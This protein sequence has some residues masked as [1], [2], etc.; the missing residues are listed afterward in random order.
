[1][2]NIN[3]FDTTLD[4]DILNYLYLD[5]HKNIDTVNYDVVTS[6]RNNIETINNFYTYKIPGNLSNRIKILIK[7]G[8]LTLDD[9]QTI[10][11]ALRKRMV[12]LLP[13]TINVSDIDFDFTVGN[14]Q[15]IDPEAPLQSQPILPIEGGPLSNVFDPGSGFFSVEVTTDLE[16]VLFDRDGTTAFIMVI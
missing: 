12:R 3:V 11:N 10:K 1:M 4:T 2:G 16:P 7:N 9:Q 14:E 8:N 6:P 5:C 13:A 15:P